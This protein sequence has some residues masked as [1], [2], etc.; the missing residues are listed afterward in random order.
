MIINFFSYLYKI[1][2]SFR[3]KNVKKELSL[4]DNLSDGWQFENYTA[5]LLKKIGYSK[6]IV[7][8]GSGD[9][10][11]DVL[12]SKSGV[13]YAIQCKLYSSSVGNKAVQEIVSGKIYYNCDKAVVITNNYFT[14]AAQKLAYATG[15]ELWDRSVL[16]QLIKQSGKF[17]NFKESTVSVV[18]PLTKV[19]LSFD[20]DDIYLLDAINYSLDQKNI[21]VSD[22]QRKFRVKYNYADYLISKMVDLEILVHDKNSHKYNVILTR[23]DFLLKYNKSAK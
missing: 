22:I 10:G 21:S 17:K 6:E 1:F 23:K 2:N 5:N 18:N 19:E 15:V 12:A 20:C 4:I 13:T 3:K 16:Q 7:T 8:S 14:S 11:V 9:N